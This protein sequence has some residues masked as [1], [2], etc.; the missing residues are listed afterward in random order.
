M[1]NQLFKA[2]EVWLQLIEIRNTIRARNI[3]VLLRL[4]IQSQENLVRKESFVMELK[5]D[6]GKFTIKMET[7]NILTTVS[8]E[9]ELDVK[10]DLLVLP[11]EQELVRGMGV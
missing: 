6:F 3:L 1:T 2:Q 5:L 4:M 9:L 10:M 8:K 11:Q 7:N